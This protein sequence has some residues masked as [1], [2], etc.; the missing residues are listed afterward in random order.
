MQIRNLLKEL[1]ISFGKGFLYGLGVDSLTWISTAYFPELAEPTILKF[2]GYA[3]AGT[4]G[5]DV[6]SQGVSWA[7]IVYGV[8]RAFPKIKRNG[9]AIREFN[10][11]VAYKGLATGI[12]MLLGNFLLSQYQT[13]PA[14][15]VD[16]FKYL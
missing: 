6:I 16:I 10:P 2:P 3:P 12:G 14:P 9:E 11:M 8:F 7:R 1:S 15:Q 4:H 13:G 5:D